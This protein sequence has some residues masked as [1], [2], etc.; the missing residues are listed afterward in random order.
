LSGRLAGGTPAALA[1]VAG[2]IAFY[3]SR[4][5][6]AV[7]RVTRT[8]SDPSAHIWLWLACVAVEACAMAAT[9]ARFHAQDSHHLVE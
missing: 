1:F 8:W 7:V 6:D 3:T 4:S 9:Y 2:A 5:P